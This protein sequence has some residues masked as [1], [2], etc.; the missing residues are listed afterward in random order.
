VNFVCGWLRSFETRPVINVITCRY[1]KCDIP[2]ASNGKLHGKTIAIKDSIPV[3]S[4]PMMNGSQ[5]LEGFIP[6][7]DATVVTR[8]LDHGARV[9]GKATCEDLCRDGCSFTSANGPVRHPMDH[10]RM[11]CGSSS[12]CAVLVSN[13]AIVRA[14]IITVKHLKTIEFA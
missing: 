10:S 7:I 4:V 14:F 5:I 13:K 6:D 1:W 12:G 8:V 11:A 2:G 9:V 3:A